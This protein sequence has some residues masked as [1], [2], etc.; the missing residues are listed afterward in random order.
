MPTGNAGSSFMRNLPSTGYLV[1]DQAFDELTERNDVPLDPLTLNGLGQAPFNTRLANNGI[2]G[3]IVWIFEGSLVVTTPSGSCT[4]TYQWPHNVI[5]QATLNANGQTSIKQMSGLT[6]RQ[7][8]QR[9]YRN[10]SESVISAVNTDTV[11]S[12]AQIG[13][14]GNPRPGS[15]SAG[16][17]A[18]TLA[19]EMPIT[20]NDAQMIGGLFAQSDQNYLSYQLTP[21]TTADLFTLTGG[22]TATLTGTFKPS[23]RFFDVPIAPVTGGANNAN[24]S[25]VVIPDLSWLHG[26]LQ[27]R[28]PFANTGD[29]RAP[30]IRTDGELL[31]YSA[32]I[33]NG[34][35]AQISPAALDE[36]R[37]EY[38]GNRR[39][40]VY[41]PVKHLLL[42]QQDAYNGPLEPGWI[43]FDFEKD[44]D[45]RDRVI[46]KGVAE[47]AVVC[48]IAA[49]TTINANA[50]IE[51]V[52]ETLFTGA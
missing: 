37:W 5:K 18:V 48:K 16:T 36:V 8:H 23:L 21:A 41:N 22:A 14:K 9:V 10:P 40:R 47:L 42:E 38:G 43:V 6:M 28:A 52:E 34:G 44:N 27:S 3:K 17:Y 31:S 51:Y 39:P 7:R 19:W 33:D 2:I 24:S 15:I 12:V 35:A 49:G 25:A 30:L 26:M 13:A 11:G 20:H 50:A 46:P 4:S 29:V 32:Y 1:N 45:E